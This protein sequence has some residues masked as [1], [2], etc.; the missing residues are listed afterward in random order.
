[1]LFSKYF[2]LLFTNK[3]PI[4]SITYILPYL[5]SYFHKYFYLPKLKKPLPYN[6]R[7]QEGLTL[8]L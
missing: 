8:R 2:P 6:G 7:G 4:I 1:M 3:I 5:I